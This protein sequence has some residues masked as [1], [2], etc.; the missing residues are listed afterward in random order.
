M[1]LSLLVYIVAIN[2]LRESNES[3]LVSRTHAYTCATK[4]HI[5]QTHTHVLWGIIQRLS[6]WVFRNVNFKCTRDSPRSALTI[7]RNPQSTSME[8]LVSNTVP[9]AWFKKEK[10]QLHQTQQIRLIFIFF[11]ITNI[12]LTLWGPTKRKIVINKLG[13]FSGVINHGDLESD[14]LELIWPTVGPIQPF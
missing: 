3:L 13:M 8:S 6:L 11:T 12:I 1:N 7:F 10:K 2:I 5:S 4:V 9:W 14:G